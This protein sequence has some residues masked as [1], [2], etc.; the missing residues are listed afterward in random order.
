MNKNTSHEPLFFDL[1]NIYLTSYY[2]F[3]LYQEGEPLYCLSE[4]PHDNPLSRDSD[5]V[6]ALTRFQGI[7]TDDAFP[8]VFYC[9]QNYHEHMLCII[10]PLS[11]QSTKT[12]SH[13]AYLRKHHVRQFLQYRISTAAH[14]QAIAAMRL[15]T[16]VLAA[17]G[18]T[19]CSPLPPFSN[20]SLAPASQSD[21]GTYQLQ[22]YR[23]DKTEKSLPTLPY[24]LEKEMKEAIKNGDEKAFTE[25]ISRMMT[26]TSGVHAA[27]SQKIAEY[28]AVA[29]ITEMT[30]A[31]IDGGV[32]YA[33]AYDV[34]D[35]I[36]YKLSKASTIE[37]CNDLTKDA[38]LRF[39]HLAK[40]NNS[41]RWQSP[42]VQNCKNYIMH[43]LNQPLTPSLLAEALHISKDYLLHLF[44]RHEGVTLIEYIQK[45]RVLAAQ[46]MLKYSDYDIMRIANYFQFKTQSHF[47]V[48]F[49][50]YT[51]MTPAAY[52]QAYRQPEFCDAAT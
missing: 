52:R 26:Y 42:H 38:C 1:Q 11:I 36:I 19:E 39:L 32:P 15:V 13:N 25:I 45:E 37:E 9:V 46:N 7:V 17:H 35:I 30:R 12:D 41:T 24:Q 16:L 4:Y 10:G 33:D 44:P 43:H 49:K 5:L 29:L 34:S 31:V 20:V 18:I 6:R 47:G 22:E 48:V 2:P 50:K 40:R 21:K 14:V 8:D 23:L 3:A 28:S 51:D 27:T